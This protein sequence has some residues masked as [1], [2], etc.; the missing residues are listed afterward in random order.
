MIRMA[1]QFPKVRILLDHMARPVLDDGLPY[2]AA[3]SL[4]ELAKIPTIYL[5]LTPRSFIEARKGKATP[6]TFFPLLISKFSASRLAW[7]SNYPSS[8]GS[9]PELLGLA[10][11]ALATLPQSG[12]EW[13]FHKTAQSLY[14]VLA[15]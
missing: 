1:E 15:K 9:L 2:A 13:I 12:Q 10:T 7:G 11:T 4:F 3:D 5:K 6:E 14:P 8:E